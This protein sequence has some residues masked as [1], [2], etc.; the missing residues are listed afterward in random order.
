[1][2]ERHGPNKNRARS[3]GRQS[4]QLPWGDIPTVGSRVRGAIPGDPPA[5]PLPRHEESAVGPFPKRPG[6]QDGDGQSRPLSSFL[7]PWEKKLPALVRGVIGGPRWWGLD[8]PTPTGLAVVSVTD[9]QVGEETW[10]FSS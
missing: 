9:I 3:P 7:Q 2:R 1:M 5:R 6:A 4:S 10:S 8:A